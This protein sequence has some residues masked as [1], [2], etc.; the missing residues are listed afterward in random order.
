VS[1]FGR[2]RRR[3]PL[4]GL[5]WVLV[6]LLA[7]VP[8][9]AGG[10]SAAGAS[11]QQAPT[12]YVK[13]YV[14]T[15]G[16]DGKPEDL[17]EI[18]ARF[19]G[20]AA[21]S[22]EIFDLNV[23]VPQPDGGELKNPNLID[24]GWVLTLPWD[25]VGPGV[26]YG[27][28][29]Q[30]VIPP[31]P[32]PPPAPVTH[33]RPSRHRRPPAR[34]PTG[35]GCATTPPSTA[36]AQDDW[37]TLRVAPQQAWPFSR[38][39]GVKVAVLDSGVD[40]SSPELAGRVTTGADVVSGTALANTDCLG[41]GTAMAGIIAANAGATGGFTGMAPAAT[42]V[43]VKVAPTRSAAPA[44]DQAS[45]VQ[46]AVAAGAKVIALGSYIDPDLPAVA[47]V[48]KQAAARNVV[49]VAPAPARSHVSA[50]AIAAA[51][52]V[53]W[54][55]A[56]TI[57]GALAWNYQPGLVDV[58][59]PGTDVASVGIAGTGGFVGSGTQYAV[60]FVA[61]EAALV[62]ARYPKLT[63]AQVVR[64]MELTAS[65]VGQQV[66]DATYGWGLI[67]P[68][69]AVTRVIP[70]E[71]PPPRH[72]AAP[73]PARWTALRT[74]ALI[75]IAV[76]GLLVFIALFLRI[77]RSVRADVLPAAPQTAAGPASLPG[78]GGGASWPGATPPGLPGE[79]SRAV[80]EVV[81]ADHAAALLGGA[82]A[83]AAS[84][85]GRGVGHSSWSPGRRSPAA[86][87]Q[88]QVPPGFES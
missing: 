72:P 43:P 11:G 21:R 18:A 81:L 63:A 35:E 70:G 23:G 71:I 32:P 53:A 83:P 47:A 60:A 22:K 55:G 9:A 52:G 30:A 20:S 10:G 28:R 27:L 39:A 67:D 58:V 33:R 24:V 88:D 69:A 64:R 66:P 87:M 75:I 12:G 48:I 41:S 17:A 36:G 45:A 44:E 56:I 59:A 25:A 3:R 4:A 7:L 19:L 15:S 51:P 2:A 79:G 40:A 68:D 31:P 80:E 8:L 76:L 73:K 37:A 57:N 42:I 78:P 61:G 26:V 46:V 50:P 62:R 34:R 38:G 74:R 29:S 13:Y 77:W 54:V 85:A 16:F 82:D 86:R 5:S 84:A 1:A 49:V 65:P 6:I 14:V